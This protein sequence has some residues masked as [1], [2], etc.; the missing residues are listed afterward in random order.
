MK[1][2][3]VLKTGWRGHTEEEKT[4]GLQDELAHTVQQIAFCRAILAKQHKWVRRIELWELPLILW[5]LF[6]E[7]PKEAIFNQS[8][9]D[10]WI[11]EML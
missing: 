11:T 2:E 4:L 1:T 8:L 5:D 7:L 9:N 3:S 10:G 6:L